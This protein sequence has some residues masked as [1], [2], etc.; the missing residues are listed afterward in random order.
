MLGSAILNCCTFFCNEFFSLRIVF[1]PAILFGCTGFSFYFF[2]WQRRVTDRISKSL[3]SSVTL[4]Y[5][6]FAEGSSK[7]VNESCGVQG[8]C[9]IVMC[10]RRRELSKE[11]TGTK[12]NDPL[13]TTSYTML[14]IFVSIRVSM[15]SSI[16]LVSFFMA[17]SILLEHSL[18]SLHFFLDIIKFISGFSSYKVSK[19]SKI[20]F[21]GFCQII[22]F[23]IDQ[24]SDCI[25]S[26]VYEMKW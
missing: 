1:F 11:L 24:R 26:N 3:G 12:E 20:H 23:F 4:V 16:T 13:H 14:M 9:R 8:C 21:K 2:L 15:L 22:Y 19:L 10:A 25:K 7:S 6:L 17:S 18:N 5:C